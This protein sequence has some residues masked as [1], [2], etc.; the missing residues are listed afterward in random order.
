[1]I[2]ETAVPDWPVVVIRMSP[3]G[4]A[5]VDGQPVVPGPAEDARDAAMSRAMYAAQGLGRPVRV[6]AHES[7]GTLFPLIVDPSGAVTEAGPPVPPASERRGLLRR[8]RTTAAA[9]PPRPPAAY[10]EPTRPEPE[11]ASSGVRV[12]SPVRAVPHTSATT[13]D[14]SLPRPAAHHVRV[15]DQ[16]RGLAESGDHPAALRLLAELQPDADAEEAV[17]LGEV[18]AYLAFLEGDAVRA[19]RLYT[20]AALAWF[21]LRGAA[22]SWALGLTESAHYS[23]GHVDDPDE[24]FGI[25][26]ELL[27]A[28][29]ALGLADS[30]RA[31][32]ARTRLE[33]TRERLL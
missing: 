24:A 31:D 15:L 21:R 8:R 17:A 25:G 7:D 26:R 29:L 20:D 2:D 23:W 32:V 3:D 4:R 1:M 18:R 5:E 16:V 19:A 27:A 14:P 11:F 33:R 30:P 10:T 28:Y 12:T 22:D 6:D 13:A 9:E